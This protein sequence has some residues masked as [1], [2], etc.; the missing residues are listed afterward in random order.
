MAKRT[1]RHLETVRGV[2]FSFPG[3]E[4]GVCYGTPGFYVRG[5][6]LARLREDGE[7]LAVKCGNEARDLRLRSDPRS[8]FITDHYAGHPTVVVRLATVRAADLHAV[9]E[10]AWRRIAPKRLVAEYDS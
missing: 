4:E 1:P 8:F 9:V 2:A 6:V 5:K 7:T 3:V 10:A